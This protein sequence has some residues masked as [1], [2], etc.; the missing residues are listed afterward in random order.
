MVSKSRAQARSHLVE[1]TFERP[2]THQPPGEQPQEVLDSMC[3][4]E[5]EEVA[6]QARLADLAP[7]ARAGWQAHEPA[8]VESH[9]AEALTHNGHPHPGLAPLGNLGRAEELVHPSHK[10]LFEFMTQRCTDHVWPQPV[11]HTIRPKDGHRPPSATEEG[12]KARFAYTGQA[13]QGG[14]SAPHQPLYLSIGD[15]D[16]LDLKTEGS[17]RCFD[18]ALRAPQHRLVPD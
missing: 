3:T 9:R 13:E 8:T 2:A 18:P 7:H 6:R 17:S 4:N 14:T 15:I 5:P 10:G 11:D 12:E 1:S 16:W